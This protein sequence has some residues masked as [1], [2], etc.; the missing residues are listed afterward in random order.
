[1]KTSKKAFGENYSE[2]FK[3]G[4]LIWWATWEQREDFTIDNVIH[5]GVLIEIT[6]EPSNVSGKENCMAT[7]LPYG[8]QKT[9]KLHIMLLR[10]ETN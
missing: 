5:R 3:V 8:Q 4:D 1:M 6:N 2:K 9:I 10:K 7:V